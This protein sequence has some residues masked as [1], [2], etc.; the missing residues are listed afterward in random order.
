MQDRRHPSSTFDDVWS[1]LSGVAAFMPNPARRHWHLSKRGQWVFNI[2]SSVFIALI[3][4]GWM[5]SIVTTRDEA[6]GGTSSTASI[7]SHA[8]TDS[9]SPSVA[10][11]TEAALDMVTP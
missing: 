10:F 3:A 1:T 11:L 5:W 2:G 6:I 4:I 7:I 8:L 9:R